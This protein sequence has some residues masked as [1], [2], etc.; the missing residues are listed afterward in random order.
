[1]PNIFPATERRLSRL[2]PVLFSVGRVF[3]RPILNDKHVIG[4]KWTTQK[5]RRANVSKI[6]F[7]EDA[8]ACWNHKALGITDSYITMEKPTIIIKVKDGHS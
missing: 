2:E 3:S 4:H 1:M 7:V 8:L 6:A 5:Y